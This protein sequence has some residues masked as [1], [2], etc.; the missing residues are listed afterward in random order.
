MTSRHLSLTLTSAG[1]GGWHIGSPPDQRMQKT[2]RQQGLDISNGRAAQ[3]QAQDIHTTD[4]FVA[5]DNSNKKNLKNILGPEAKIV[6]LLDFHNG[7]E[8]EVPDPYYGG[9]DGFEQVYKLVESGVKG[10]F[11]SLEKGNTV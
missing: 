2:A 7:P 1:T 4:L 9:D 6:R 11:D 10:L 8:R 3:V 5:M